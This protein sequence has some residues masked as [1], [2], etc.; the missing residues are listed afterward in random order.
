MNKLCRNTLVRV[1][2]RGLLVLASFV[3]FSELFVFLTD[4]DMRLFRNTLYYQMADLQIDRVSDDAERLFELVPGASFND[5]ILHAKENRCV[6]RVVTINELG[7]RDKERQIT[8]KEGVFR[9]VALGGSNTFGAVVCDEETYPAQLER[10]FDQIQPGSV[11]VWNA[12]V[13]SYVLSQK[14]AYAKRVIERFD[15]DLLIFQHNNFSSRAFY[16]SSTLKDLK[17]L[18]RK[19]RDLYA[20]NM[21]WL[22]ME[23]HPV[24]AT[25]HKWLVP[26]SGLYRTLY[27]GAVRWLYKIDPG[28][29][30]KYRYLCRA[31][32][33]TIGGNQFA[34]LAAEH[35]DMPMIVFHPVSYSDVIR[36]FSG[37]NIRYLHLDNTNYPEEYDD[38]HPPSYVYERYATELAKFMLRGGYFKDTPQLDMSLR[39]W[40]RRS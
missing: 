32:E 17:E 3:I 26:H 4:V 24:A 38:V 9:I 12:G 1:I 16:G 28:F 34:A 2:Q 14:V 15:P 7:F 21:P 18:F 36:V 5:E 31:A 11:E 39:R 25:L 29:P 19:N 35:Q 23:P 10:L 40:S 6:A 30:E 8:K 33:C 37:D 13:H 20:E 27:A 22:S